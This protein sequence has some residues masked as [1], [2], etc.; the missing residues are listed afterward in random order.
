LMKLEE[1]TKKELSQKAEQEQ[2]KWTL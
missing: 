1:E 2:T